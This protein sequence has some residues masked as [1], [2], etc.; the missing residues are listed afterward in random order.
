LVL[1]GWQ[2]DQ[3]VLKSLVPGITPMNPMTAIHFIL[4][5]T[6]LLLDSSN[7]KKPLNTIALIIIFFGTLHFVTDILP[8]PQIRMDF[9]LYGDKIPQ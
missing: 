6:W 9:W 5:G 4:A 3:P 7:N 2:T 1:I 8:L